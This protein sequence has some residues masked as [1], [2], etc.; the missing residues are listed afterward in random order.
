MRESEVNIDYDLLQ[1]AM[2]V[3]TGAKEVACR[4]EPQD[5]IEEI[6]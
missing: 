1:S 2:K 3:G 6:S 5:D 4:F